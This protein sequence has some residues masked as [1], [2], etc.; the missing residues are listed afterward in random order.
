[1]QV[2]PIFNNFLAEEILKLDLKPIQDYCLNLEK[3]TPSVL[4]SNYGGWHSENIDPT[5]TPLK[6]LFTEIYDRVYGLHEFLGFKKDYRQVVSQAWI[7]INRRGD[8]NVVHT[9]PG[10]FFSGCFYVKV[11]ENSGRIKFATPISEHCWA[12][13]QNQVEERNGY[14]ASTMTVTPQEN[15]LLI[16][17]PW[18]PHHVIG[19]NSDESRI[20]IAF[21]TTVYLPKKK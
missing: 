13:S 2:N 14:N 1:M 4:I 5:E 8:Y 18:L 11:P 3:K 9:H 20:S 16:F 19:S 12:I 21:N 6:P 15:M 7:N 10:A 17:P